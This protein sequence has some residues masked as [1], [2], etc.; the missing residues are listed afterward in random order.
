MRDQAHVFEAQLTCDS[1]KLRGERLSSRVRDPSSRVRPPELDG[2]VV[3]Q[4]G[5]GDDVLGWVAGGAQDHVGV[6]YT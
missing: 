4:A 6:P 5:R 1:Y 2:L 3:L